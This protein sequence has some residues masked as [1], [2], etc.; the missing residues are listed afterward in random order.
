[1]SYSQMKNWS[2]NEL[3]NR[4]LKMGISLDKN[5]HE[6][7]YYENLYL[8]QLNAKNKFTRNNNYFG[9]KQQLL[10]NKRER[11]K[12]KGKEEDEDKDDANLSPNDS[13]NNNNDEEEINENNNLNELNESEANNNEIEGNNKPEINFRK[14]KTKDIIELNKNYKE[15]GIKYTRLI[16]MKKK[17]TSEKKIL[18]INQ[19]NSNTKK[20]NS[21]K[22]ISK[23]ETKSSKLLNVEPRN[24]I[25]KRSPLKRSKNKSQ[26][27]N[28]E[29]NEF[30]QESKNIE[31]NPFN[32][33]KDISLKVKADFSKEKSPEQKQEQK[34]ILFGAPKYSD[35]NSHI[36]LSEGP[37]SFGVN[38]STNSKNLGNTESNKDKNYNL[39]V[40]N[41]SDAVKENLKESQNIAEKKAK[42]ILLKCES[43]WQKEFMRRSMDLE[44]NFDNSDNKINISYNFNE[45]LKN[46]ENENINLKAPNQIYGNDYLKG[47]NIE[48]D[49]NKYKQKYSDNNNKMLFNN[50]YI[51]EGNDNSGFKKESLFGNLHKYDAENKNE[52]N[53]IESQD[54]YG[55]SYQQKNSDFNMNNPDYNKFDNYKGNQYM[56]NFN[57]P[58]VDINNDNYHEILEDKIK[59]DNMDENININNEN[60]KDIYENDLEIEKYQE[61]IEQKNKKR[62]WLNKISGIKNSIM[63][64]FKN[65]A[66]LCPLILLILFGIVYF[67]NDTYERFENIHIIIVF[68]ILMGLLVLYNLMRYFLKKRNY[69]KM[70]KSDRIAL[71]N[72]LNDNNITKEDIGN[73]MVLISNFI[74][75]RIT[76]HNINQ[77]EYMKYVFHYLCK[78]LKKDGF[79]LNIDENNNQNYWKEI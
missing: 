1:M 53:Y 45:R 37:I 29:N 6:R 16:P 67:L 15:S 62:K 17:K 41:I 43:P 13:F 49:N 58:N 7:E 71:L 9:R 34:P 30:F 79:E 44:N 63:N 73:N 4:L 64:R 20:S 46:Y 22:K 31:N 57:N 33:N 3:K 59:Y 66:F 25:S 32:N 42:S 40:K 68:S 24:D 36:F 50:D 74:S 48:D 38:Q 18:S 70:A 69:K 52:I 76:E 47:Q 78:Y 51:Q 26:K 75:Q 21:V 2:K 23:S 27:K 54:I 19:V 35:N 61:E 65:N 12:S 56:N 77:D 60:D 39:F 14:M 10:N 55:N 5:E 72:L 28:T 8:Q 11:N